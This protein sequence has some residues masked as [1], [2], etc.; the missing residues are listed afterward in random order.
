MRKRSNAS[1]AARSTRRGSS[2]RGRRQTTLRARTPGTNRG[3]RTSSRTRA[4]RGTTYTAHITTDYETIR[5]WAETRGGW[6]AMVART[7]RGDTACVLRIDFPA[8][9]GEGTLKPISWN[10]WFKEFDQNNLAFLY[11][12]RTADGK[13]TR[14]YKLIEHE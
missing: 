5:E 11:Q 2:K 9:T 3:R 10:E 13:Q 6:P 12:E 4:R 1:K 8:Y 7:A 14:F